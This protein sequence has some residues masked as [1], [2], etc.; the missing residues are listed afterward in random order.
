MKPGLTS[1]QK[2]AFN[3]KDWDGETQW[4]MV[5]DASNNWALNSAPSGLDSFKAYQ[6]SN[7]GDTYVN[8]THRSGVVRVNYESGTGS[9]FNIYGGDDSSLYASFSG[10]ASIGFPGLAAGNGRNCLQIDAAGSM[11]NTGSPCSTG[12]GT[13]SNGNAGQIAYYTGDGAAVGGTSTIP[14]TAGGTGASTAAGALMALAAASLATSTAQSFQGPLNAPS[15][16]ASVNTE[17][18]VRASPFNAKGDG[19]TDDAA[20]INAACTAA[21]A[22]NSSGFGGQAS[23]QVYFPKPP[24]GFYLV[25]TLTAC[26]GVSLKGQPGLGNVLRGRFGRHHSGQTGEGHSSRS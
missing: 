21:N 7:G 14:V 23:A 15:V 20:A 24:G 9:A 16:N 26:T 10:A 11:S 19:V 6:S 18:N 2:G 5:K 4:S 1:S 3:Y 25:S 22:Y 13:V 8:A 12:S 17:I